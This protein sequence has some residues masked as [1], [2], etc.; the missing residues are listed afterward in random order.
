MAKVV[1]KKSAAWEAAKVI[2]LERV[3]IVE[4]N[5]PIELYEQQREG[6]LLGDL[7]LLLGIRSTYRVCVNESQLRRALHE[8]AD[9]KF[10]AVHIS[11]HGTTQGIT[12]TNGNAVSWSQLAK[13]CGSKMKKKLLVISACQSG[14]ADLAD[15]L[16]ESSRAPSVIVGTQEDIEWRKA[17]LAWQL[18]YHWLADRMPIN[19]A[20]KK[21]EAVLDLNLTYRRWTGKRYIPLREQRSGL[22]PKD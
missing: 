13:M 15:A 4:S 22:S 2:A 20:L 17:A 11:C 3:L 21:V 6:V 19:K 18:L 12:L 16:S 14:Q 8:A 9:Q 5:D 1:H 7:L 10:D